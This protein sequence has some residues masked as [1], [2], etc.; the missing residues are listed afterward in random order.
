M[1]CADPNNGNL[2]VSCLVEELTDCF[3]DRHAFQPSWVLE[4]KCHAVWS[5]EFRVVAKICEEVFELLNIVSGR[6]E[7]LLCLLY[8]HLLQVDL[9][10]AV[11]LGGAE[12]YDHNFIGFKE[13]SSQFLLY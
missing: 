6:F 8:G 10:G 12:G 5:H 9:P 13:V 1:G 2:L 3:L 11:V 4:V 7:I